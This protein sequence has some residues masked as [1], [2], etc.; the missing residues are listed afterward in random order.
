MGG[1][2]AT[3][4]ALGV[5]LLKEKL[6]N[7]P[8]SMKPIQPVVDGLIRVLTDIGEAIDLKDGENDRELG[9]SNLLWAIMCISNFFA[10]L[11]PK[12]IQYCAK[13]K[14]TAKVEQQNC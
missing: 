6:A 14:P 8:T 13:A 9:N 12:L 11:G 7:L 4:V 10:A 2:T 3:I 5:E 1:N